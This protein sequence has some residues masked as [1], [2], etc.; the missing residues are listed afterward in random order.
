MNRLFISNEA[1]YRLLRT[2]IQGDIGQ[3]AVVDIR[4][5]GK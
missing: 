2:I 1:K 4:R 5:M 3:Y